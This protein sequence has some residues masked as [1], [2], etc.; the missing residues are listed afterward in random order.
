MG[1]SFVVNILIYY[2]FSQERIKYVG[3][4]H[5]ILIEIIQAEN[6]DLLITFKRCCFLLIDS[7]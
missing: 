4:G 2:S 6:I 7:G 5:E 1:L 3:Q